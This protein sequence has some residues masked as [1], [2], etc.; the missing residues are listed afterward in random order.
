MRPTY[1]ASIPYRRGRL[2][3][4]IRYRT[5]Y[6]VG[7]RFARI[8][9]RRAPVELA[10]RLAA[11]WSARSRIA[12]GLHDG[13]G[14]VDDIADELDDLTTT[15]TIVLRDRLDRRMAADAC[16]RRRLGSIHPLPE[17]ML[18]NALMR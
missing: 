7:M 10:V 13:R 9:A 11:R 12:H 16:D 3:H 6:A 5:T 2:A 8:I 15:I 4:R 18:H 1:L 14:W 17:G